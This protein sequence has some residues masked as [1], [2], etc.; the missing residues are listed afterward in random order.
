MRQPPRSVDP[1]VAFQKHRAQLRVPDRIPDQRE[2]LRQ[3]LARVTEE[4]AVSQQVPSSPSPPV[5][6]IPLPSVVGEKDRRLC[7]AWDALGPDQRAALRVAEA[8]GSQSNRHFIGLGLG[9]VLP[10]AC[11]PGILL[12]L[13]MRRGG[14]W[15]A[16]LIV[17]C[18]GSLW[19]SEVQANRALARFRTRLGDA[20]LKVALAMDHPGRYLEALEKLE[21]AELAGWELLRG[22]FQMERPYSHRRER[23]CAR[24]GFTRSCLQ[25][26]VCPGTPA[27]TQKDIDGAVA[28]AT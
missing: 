20:D 10:A 22:E 3:V 13:C 6:T 28:E 8:L 5:T 4:A 26:H 25:D 9:C 12:G 15:T 19:W 16:G 2:A 11:L 18:L 17:V 7:E 23:L 24:L 14:F 27:A 1:S 21:A